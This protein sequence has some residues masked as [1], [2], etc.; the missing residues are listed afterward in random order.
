MSQGLIVDS[1]QDDVVRNVKPSLLAVTGAVLVLLVIACVNVIHLQVARGAQRRSEFAMRAALGA[2]RRRLVRQLLTE[3]LF[4]SVLGGAAG[5]L[6]AEGGVRVLRSFAPAQMPRINAVGVDG[7]VFLIVFV[8]SLLVGIASGLIPAL[9]A[10][11]GDLQRNIRVQSRYFAGGQ[12]LTRRTLVVAEVALAFV[13]LVSA[14]LLLRSLRQL[15]AIEPGFHA[16]G[17]LVMQVQATSTRRFPNGDNV[18]RFFDQSLQ[19]VRR[20]PGVTSAGFTSQLPL[21]G[22]DAAYISFAASFERRADNLIEK[23]SSSRYAVSPGYFETMNIPL[24][25]GRFFNED[26]RPGSSPRP[27]IIGESFAKHVFGSMSPIGQRVRFG[28]APDRPWDVIVG[29]VGDVRQVSLAAEESSALYA[30]T[31]Q[32]LWADN[33]LWLVVRTQGDPVGLVAAIRNAIWSVDKDQPIARVSTM[34]ALLAA[35]ASERRFSL[36][37][38]EAFAFGAVVLAG[39]GLYALLAGSVSERMREIGIRTALGASSRDIVGLV[40]REGMMLGGIGA[41]IGSV[42]AIV[43]SRGIETMLFGVSPLDPL[44]YVVMIVLLLGVT[45]SA[46]WLPALRAA[47]IDPCVTLRTE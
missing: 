36:I 47:R 4:L 15:F 9:C 11:A 21:S 23:F 19:A 37:V 34:E 39:T 25:S 2:R 42:A 24:R 6:I 22:D 16:S 30:N 20:V 14:G 32:W 31:D 10:F 41:V 46:S 1:L 12:L 28:G 44:T 33:P 29:V 17:L 27:V 13:L 5:L 3:G 26:D 38:F 8:A 18:H 45:L 7:S 35:S 40:L 43:A